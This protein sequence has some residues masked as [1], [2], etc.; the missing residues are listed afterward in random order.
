MRETCPGKLLK[1]ICCI[2]FIDSELTNHCHLKVAGDD[3]GTNVV[4]VL[5]ITVYIAFVEMKGIKSFF[6]PIFKF[7]DNQSGRPF[8]KRKT[9]STKAIFAPVASTA[10]GNRDE[11]LTVVSLVIMKRDPFISWEIEN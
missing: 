10:S 6:N 5:G 9:F 2:S 7:V 8:P 4:K 11:M 1:I 3:A